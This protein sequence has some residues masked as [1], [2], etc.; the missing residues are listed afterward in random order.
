[1]EQPQSM[2]APAGGLS[3]FNAGLG[4]VVGDRV[5]T[6]VFVCGEWVGMSL[7]IV[8]GQSSDGSVSSVDIMSLHGG[9][10]RIQYEQTGHLRK[11]V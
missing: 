1:M 7:G 10:P 8:V 9:S 6:G 4:V 2:K 11:E 3:E 5:R